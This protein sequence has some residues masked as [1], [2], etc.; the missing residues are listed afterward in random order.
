MMQQDINLFGKD[1]N[2]N[3]ERVTWMN[4]QKKHMVNGLLEYMIRCI[5]SL[6]LLPF[7]YYQ[8]LPMGVRRLSSG[9]GRAGLLCH[10]YTLEWLL[11]A[12]MLQNPWSPY[13]A[14]NLKVRESQSRWATSRMY[15]WM[16]N[17]HSFT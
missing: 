14:A 17:I 4:T 12:L 8:S 9:L 6:T 16:V 10:Y 3:Q 13:S 11:M 1:R 15:L 7:R 5:P 2:Y